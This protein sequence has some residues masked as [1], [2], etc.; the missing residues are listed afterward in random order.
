MTPITRYIGFITLVVAMVL[1]AWGQQYLLYAPQ[2]VPQGQKGAAQ[3]G[4][5]VQEIEVQ[6]GDTLFG[7]SRKFSGHGMYYP[8]ILLFNSIK[9]PNRIYPGLT[10]KIPVS[11]KE[12]PVSDHAESRPGKSTATPQPSSSRKS[13]VVAAP[14]TRTSARHTPTAEVTTPSTELSLSDL[15]AI[16]KDTGSAPSQRRKKIVVR[17]KTPPREEASVGLPAWS[18]PPETS[19][20]NAVSP[21]IESGSGHKIFKAALRAYRQDDCRAALD[22]FDRYLA[23]NA[24]SPLAA[25]ANLYKA[26]CYL[27]LSAQ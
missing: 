8:Q 25:D 9:N 2:P 4:I 22:L 18:P 11:Q 10:L 16:G 17:G 19:S 24:G 1:P 23:D 12:A 21:A 14:E 7:I 26:D 3:D 5:L 20:G 27:K 13:K 6:K 15:K